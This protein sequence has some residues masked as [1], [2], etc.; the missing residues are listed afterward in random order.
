MFSKILKKILVPYDGSSYSKKALARAMEL[1][2]NLDSEIILI[3]VV[4][5]SYIAPPG[6]LQGLIKGK[7]KK[8]PMEKWKKSVKNNAK[9]ML[10][11]CVRKCKSNGVTASYV[12]KDGNISQEILDFAKKRKTTLIIIGS[13]GLAGISKLKTLGSVS[14]KV[15]EQ[16]HCPVLIVR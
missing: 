5:L 16:A 3:N 4:N 6:G 13:Q 8:S 2:H 9:K 15:S 11:S 12:I 14:R 7:S 1:A 10:E